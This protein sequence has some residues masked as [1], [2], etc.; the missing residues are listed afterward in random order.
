MKVK[1][2]SR[3]KEHHDIGKRLLRPT[4]VWRSIV[5]MKYWKLVTSDG[6]TVL[7]EIVKIGAVSVTPNDGSWES[8]IVNDI[9]DV[10][11]AA[12]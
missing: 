2:N 5:L 9:W 10:L 7:F 11:G 8:L 4:W 12:L 3:E 6:L 1:M